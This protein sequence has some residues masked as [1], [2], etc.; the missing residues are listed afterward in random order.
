MSQTSDS[1]ELSDL[2][3]QTTDDVAEED[4]IIVGAFFVL[5]A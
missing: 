5:N 4:T 2:T 1:V 3:S